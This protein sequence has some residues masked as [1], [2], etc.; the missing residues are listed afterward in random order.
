MLLQCLRLPI[1]YALH[2]QILLTIRLCAC[3]VCNACG[4]NDLTWH[5]KEG[6]W[7]NNAVVIEFYWQ[8]RFNFWLAGIY[9]RY[10]GVYLQNPT[11]PRAS[12]VRVYPLLATILPDYSQPVCTKSLLP[13][14]KD[15]AGYDPVYIALP[16]NERKRHAMPCSFWLKH[17]RCLWV[18]SKCCLLFS[19]MI[20]Y[21]VIISMH[22]SIIII[23]AN[24]T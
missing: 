9:S 4:I 20:L 14:H 7:P 21:I 2:V 19:T 3:N 1:L 18:L 12:C 24:L 5:V 17:G 22:D 8:G 15:G 6:N 11:P 10:N 16:E 13:I 23:Q